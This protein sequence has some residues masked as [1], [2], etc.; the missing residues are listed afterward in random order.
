M[1]IGAHTVLYSS[2]PNANRAF[3]RE[4]LKLAGVDAGGGFMI[5]GLPAAEVSVHES[6]SPGSH[7][8]FL[9]CD[10]VQA[11]IGEMSKGN[12]AC[13]P[14]RMRGGAPSRRSRC[15]AAES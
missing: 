12:V 9:M 11:F 4:M 15:R 10:D 3:F 2:N 5:F 8:L 1:L 7:E 14:V 6:G 13:A